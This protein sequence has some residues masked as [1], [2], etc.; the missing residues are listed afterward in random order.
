MFAKIPVTRFSKPAQ[1]IAQP[2]ACWKLQPPLSDSLHFVGS[3]G[4][5]ERELMHH[6][7]PTRASLFPSARIRRNAI[8]G[9]SPCLHWQGTAF[10]FDTVFWQYRPLIC[11][12]LALQILRSTL[13]WRANTTSRH[14]VSSELQSK[15]YRITIWGEQLRSLLALPSLDCVCI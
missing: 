15:K 9:R 6:F 8:F 4:G 5:P 7:L 12:V 3:P 10:S 1:A 14:L 11:V 2:E 13:D